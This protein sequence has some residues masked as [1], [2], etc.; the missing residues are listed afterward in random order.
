MLLRRDGKK[1]TADVGGVFVRLGFGLRALEGEVQDGL[2]LVFDVIGLHY[3]SFV[4]SGT[5][6]FVTFGLMIILLPFVF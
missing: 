1:R 2:N 4:K 3:P 6:G 5:F